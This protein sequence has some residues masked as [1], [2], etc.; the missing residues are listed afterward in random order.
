M[1]VKL[2]SSDGTTRSVQVQAM[3]AN[4]ERSDQV[5]LRRERRRDAAREAA[6]EHREKRNG[7]PLSVR[8]L[9]NPRKRAR[10]TSPKRPDI[11]DWKVS[12][13][14]LLKVHK[15]VITDEYPIC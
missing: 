1:E 10:S 13:S 3:E 5:E 2:Q 15:L 11:E 6:R 12:I 9:E 14:Y 4:G 8:E 7:D